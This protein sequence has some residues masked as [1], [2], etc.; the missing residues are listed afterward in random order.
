MKTIIPVNASIPLNQGVAVQGTI[1]VPLKETIKVPVLNQFNAKVEV[2]NKVPVSFETPLE[3]Q[4]K[5]K[6]TLKV[7]MPPLKIDPSKITISVD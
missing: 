5:I 4:A 2:L 3:A 6:D 1:I 7:N